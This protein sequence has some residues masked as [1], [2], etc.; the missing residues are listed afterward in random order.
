MMETETQEYP[1][2]FTYKST[3]EDLVEF[4]KTEQ[5]LDELRKLINKVLRDEEVIVGLSQI[6]NKEQ[7]MSQNFSVIHAMKILCDLQLDPLI[8]LLDSAGQNGT[9]FVRNSTTDPVLYL[10]RL[11]AIYRYLLT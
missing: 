6:P 2:F 11:A 3:F 4:P 8:Q 10:D 1:E 5:T 7:K 9:K